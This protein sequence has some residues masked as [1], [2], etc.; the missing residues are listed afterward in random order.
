MGHSFHYAAMKK[1]QMIDTVNWEES[2][3]NYAEYKK[4]ISKSHT[5]YDST[6]TTFFFLKVL[7]IETGPFCIK[8]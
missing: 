7:G 3:G 1:E 8:L 2:Q 5:Q 6:Y 4:V